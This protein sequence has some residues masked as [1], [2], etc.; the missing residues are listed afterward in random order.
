VIIVITLT[1]IIINS[2]HCVLKFNNV[3]RY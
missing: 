1:H 3:L 2:D